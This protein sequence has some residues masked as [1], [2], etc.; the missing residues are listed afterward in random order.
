MKLVPTGS[1]AIRSR[2]RRIHTLIRGGSNEHCCTHE[3]SIPV[4]RSPLRAVRMNSPLGMRPR[5]WGQGL[6]VN[7][8]RH[9]IGSH[10]FWICSAT[11][12]S[13]VA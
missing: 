4:S 11:T 12:F 1:Q 3:A 2:S 6:H 10:F 5:R 9:A 7:R 8:F 13:M